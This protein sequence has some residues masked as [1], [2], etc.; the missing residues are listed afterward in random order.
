MILKASRKCFFVFSALV[1]SGAVVSGAHAA[2]RI[3]SLTKKN[4]QAFIE[5]TTDI[6][7]NNSSGLSQDKIK[8]YLDEHLEDKAKFKSLMRYNIPNMPPQEAELSMDKDGFMKSVSEG[9]DS[10]TKL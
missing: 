6:T 4:I 7:T 10:V 2:E 3:K 1:L 9:A 5:E 8:A